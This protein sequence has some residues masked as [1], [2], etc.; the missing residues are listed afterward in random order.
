MYASARHV[1][2]ADQQNVTQPSDDAQLLARS[3]EVTGV[4]GLARRVRPATKG[5]GQVE[6]HTARHHGRHVLHAVAPG[7][8]TRHISGVVTV[9]HLAVTKD[10]GEAVPLSAALEEE[11][12]AVVG[13]APA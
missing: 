2:G 9:E 11:E 3:I 8:L 4:D 5:R 13:E 10:V 7:A 1:S 12:E 6:K